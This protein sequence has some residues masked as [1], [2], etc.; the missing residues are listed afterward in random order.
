MSCL[1]LLQWRGLDRRRERPR[2]RR[3]ERGRISAIRSG[4]GRAS[5]RAESGRTACRFRLSVSRPRPLALSARARSDERRSRESGPRRTGSAS[6]SLEQDAAICLA[7]HGHADV[8]IARVFQCLNGDLRHGFPFFYLDEWLFQ[9]QESRIAARLA[10]FGRVAFVVRLPICLVR[11][12][13]ISS[14]SAR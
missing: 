13:E 7:Q 8:G 9:F 5:R 1:P 14:S 11:L 4:T 6:G 12:F 2:L 3:C 10:D